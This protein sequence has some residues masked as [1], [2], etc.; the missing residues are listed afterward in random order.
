MNTESSPLPDDSCGKV[1][2][3]PNAKFSSDEFIK[4]YYTD[5]DK[6]RGL[7]PKTKYFDSFA[8]Y[9]R[10]MTHLKEPKKIITDEE[11]DQAFFAYQKDHAHHYLGIKSYSYGSKAAKIVGEI[12]ITVRAIEMLSIRKYGVS[13]SFSESVYRAEIMSKEY[14]KRIE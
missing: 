7:T 6:Q 11:I 4:W 14:M 3:N 1:I 10:F 13:Q 5:P 2:Y 9:Y 12:Q 8:K